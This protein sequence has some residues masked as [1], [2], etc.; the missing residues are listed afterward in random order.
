[1]STGMDLCSI[2][3][4]HIKVARTS[5][6]KHKADRILIPHTIKQ[7]KPM[8]NLG[9]RVALPFSAFPDGGLMQLPIVP[10]HQLDQ[11][12]RPI[13]RSQRVSA[14]TASIH[15][16]GFLQMVRHADMLGEIAIRETHMRAM[17][18]SGLS[19]PVFLDSI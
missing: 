13:R 15:Q 6:A 7:A 17:R 9:S 18:F 8:Y 3:G 14:D 10:S 1:M 19:P 11:I 16:V 5:S 4:A 2:E 12:P